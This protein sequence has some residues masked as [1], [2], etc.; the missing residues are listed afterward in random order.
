M[1][2]KLFGVSESWAR[3]VKQVRREHQRT[4][5]LPMG[6]ARVI[7]VDMDR[8]EKLVQE[9]PDA[10][11]PEL[12]ERLGADTCTVSAVTMA[13]DRL[14]LSLKK[15]RC[16]RPSRIVPTWRRSAVSGNHTTLRAVQSDTSSSMKPGPRRT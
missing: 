5:P 6:G 8:L 15:R 7:K 4:R 9:Q 11:I 13:L 14:D 1:I 10:T 3:R 12:H 16:M 2:A